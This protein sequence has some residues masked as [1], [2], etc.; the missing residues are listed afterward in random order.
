MRFAETD[1]DV[2]KFRQLQPQ[3]HLPPQ[4]TTLAAI[5][6]A[7]P[8]PGRTPAQDDNVEAPVRVRR[9]LDD[10]LWPLD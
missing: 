6:R 5:G 3:W 2:A 10:I 4:H 7:A 1:N 9:G 8:G